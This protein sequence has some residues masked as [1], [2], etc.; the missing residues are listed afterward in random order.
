MPVIR[1]THVIYTVRPGDTLYTIAA[2]F[3]STVES[4]RKANA[5]YPP[6]TDPN[7]IRPG[8]ILIVPTPAI[9]PYRTI[10]IVAQGDTLYSIGERFHAHV[11]LIAGVNRGIQNPNQIYPNYPLWVP[12]FVYEVAEG[13]SLWRISQRLGIPLSQLLR[14]NEGRPGL[15]IDLVYPG[16]RLVLPLP[17]S[18]NIAVIRPYPGDVVQDGLQVEGFA[19]AFEANVLLQ[20]RDDNQNTV[21][22]ER[23]TTAREGGPAYGYFITTLPFDRRPTT[24]GGELWVYARSARDGSII[25]LVQVRVYFS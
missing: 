3:G 21:S 5:V 16:Y 23:F 13:D 22:K 17:T 11:D 10:Y 4:I 19:R 8:W 1:E 25:D 15:S 18:R 20:I 2:Q 14:A 24:N 12:A 6:I 7:L 9:K